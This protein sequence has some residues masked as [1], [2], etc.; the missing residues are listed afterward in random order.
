MTRA[1]DKV[2]RIGLTGGI[3]SGKSLVAGFFADLGVPIIDT[4][5]VA[6]DVTEPGQPALREISD[7][8]GGD[9]IR[10]DGRL[11][12]RRLRRLIFADASNR[13][14]LEAILHP[15]IRRETL[16]RADRA[17]GP[18][19]VFVVPLLLE[20]GFGQL[21][22]RVLVIDCPVEMQR[23]RLLER[24]A[25]DPQQVDRILAA[26]VSRAERLAAADDVIDNSGTIEATRAQVATLH[27]RYLSIAAAR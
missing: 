15:R 22:D 18:Y 7:R 12:R 8:F 2:L 26:Q 11:D 25:E 6:R 10:P 27:D 5:R 16:A 3:A 13:A 4:D 17:G 20:S 14:A 1:S 21:V 24:D 19:Q 9:I 23:M